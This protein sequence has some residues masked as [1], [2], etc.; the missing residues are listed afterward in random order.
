MRVVF[1]YDKKQVLR[2]LR[3]HF[4]TKKDIRLLLILVNAFTLL[5]VLLYYF[6]KVSPLAFLISSFLWISLML[7]F[8]FI[9]PMNIY[10]TSKTFQEDLMVEFLQEEMVIHHSKGE[11]A[12]PYNSFQSIRETPDFFYLYINDRS[13]FLI[14]Q[15]A[16]PDTD[17]TMAFRNLLNKGRS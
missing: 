1:S 17:S 12:W 9:M 5:S 4:F 8:W 11:K 10:R 13:F 3:Y 16:F 6:E 14:P 2:A 7:S 15:A